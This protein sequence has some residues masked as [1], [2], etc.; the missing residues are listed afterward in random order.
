ML[1]FFREIKG[2]FD[3][4]TG[5]WLGLVIFEEVEILGEGVVLLMTGLD[6]VK[7]CLSGKGSS[8]LSSATEDITGGIDPGWNMDLILSPIDILRLVVVGAG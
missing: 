5:S 1:G 7:E 8:L 3:G 6:L 4:L 2:E